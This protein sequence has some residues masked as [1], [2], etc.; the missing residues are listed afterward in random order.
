MSLPINSISIRLAGDARSL[1]GVPP[2]DQNT[3]RAPQFFRGTDLTV[4]F[5]AFDTQGF[6]I[7]FSNVTYVEFDL[8]P[9][10]LNQSLV[11]TTYG[12]S[13]Y[14]YLPFPSVPPAPLL[15]NTVVAA[16]ITPTVTRAQ[17][18]AGK[19]QAKGR[20]GWIYTAS[21]NLNGEQY[22]RFVLVVRAMT[23]D[24]EQLVY[25][26]TPITVYESNAQSIYLPN[27][28]APSVVPDE[29]IFYVAPNSQISFAETIAV[30]CGGQVVVG[31]DAILTQL[32]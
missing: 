31:Q 22:A 32:N 26:A 10:P 5:A 4:D 11:G 15:F 1:P 24:N 28:V 12:Y 30:D 16:D 9:Y 8:Y 18:Q 19:A 6:C 23:E 21:L 27:T 25:F 7:D 2:V 14:S 3:G 13:P 20:F 29:T 17:W